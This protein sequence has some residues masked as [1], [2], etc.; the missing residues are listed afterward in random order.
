MHELMF[1]HLTL[2]AILIYFKMENAVLQMQET[3]ERLLSNSTPRF[4]TDDEG[5]IEQPSSVLG[6][7]MLKFLVR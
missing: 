4:L 5:F 3:K 6:Y 7:N 1:L 2:R